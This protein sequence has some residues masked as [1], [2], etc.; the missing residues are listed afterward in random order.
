MRHEWPSAPS[1]WPSRPLSH[2]SEFPSSRSSPQCGRDR[3]VLALCDRDSLS[4]QPT[5]KL[6]GTLG[7]ADRDPR[8]RNAGTAWRPVLR[9]APHDRVDGDTRR[10]AAR[11]PPTCPD[12]TWQC[13]AARS[14]PP[15]PPRGSPARIAPPRSGRGHV[16]GVRPARRGWSPGCRSRP[17]PMRR[18]VLVTSSAATSTLLKETSV[19]ATRMSVL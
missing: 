18:P 17:T 2:R 4:E 5:G 14:S 11:H 12:G 19:A 15:L 9:P 3:N 8:A 7:D 1:I 6:V 16:E 10:R 13:G